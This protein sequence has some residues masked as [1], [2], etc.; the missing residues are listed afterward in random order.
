MRLYWRLA[1]FA[2]VITLAIAATSTHQSAVARPAPSPSP[3]PTNPPTPYMDPEQVTNGTWDVIMQKE[4]QDP[5][6]STMKLKDVGTTVSGVWIADRKTVYDLKGKRD[7]KHLILDISNQGKP[8]VVVGKIDAE[9]DGIADIVG[10][11]TLGKVDT[12]FQAAQHSRVPPPVEA[13]PRPNAT[14]TP[15]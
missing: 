2:V 3:S 11:L 1:L 12:P 8:D 14:R 15:Y 13:S 10:T 4:G 7:G 5:S 6:Y 9:I